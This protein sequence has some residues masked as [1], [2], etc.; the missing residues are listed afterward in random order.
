LNQHKKIVS[1]KNLDNNRISKN[2]CELR[3][4]KNRMK[5]S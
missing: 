4:N 5:E 1:I 3:S 2:L